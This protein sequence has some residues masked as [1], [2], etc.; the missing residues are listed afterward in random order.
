[1]IFVEEVEKGLVPSVTMA[2]M[3]QQQTV[4]KEVLFGTPES[5]LET[6]RNTVVRELIKEV[7][8]Q[9]VRIMEDYDDATK[10]VLCRILVTFHGRLWP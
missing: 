1:M 3:G 2:G 4:E 9:A 5:R 10:R 8:P 6:A 7:N